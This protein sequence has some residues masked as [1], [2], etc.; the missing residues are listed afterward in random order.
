MAHQP[1]EKR[2]GMATFMTMS[3]DDCTGYDGATTK[4]VHDA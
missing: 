3:H 4:G 2:A 1:H